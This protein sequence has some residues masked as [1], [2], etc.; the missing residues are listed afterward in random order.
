MEAV[1][2]PLG[3]LLRVH[4]IDAKAWDSSSLG[5]GPR[6]PDVSPASQG[7]LLQQVI[8]KA[9]GKSTVL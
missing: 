7:I 2:N 5:I 6:E 8:R 1:H 3:H 9:P 4:F